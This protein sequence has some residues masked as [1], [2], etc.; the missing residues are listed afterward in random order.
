MEQEERNM[1]IEIH[2]LLETCFDSSLK[3]LLSFVRK[4]TKKIEPS[5]DF[6]SSLQ[7]NDEKW[8]SWAVMRPVKSS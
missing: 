5:E 3:V 6:E 1:I 4:L 8:V 2:N 7:M